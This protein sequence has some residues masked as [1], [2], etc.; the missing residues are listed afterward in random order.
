MRSQGRAPSEEGEIPIE[1]SS[2][3]APTT[4]SLPIGD[5]IEQGFPNPEKASPQ[6]PFTATATTPIAPSAAQSP[7]P[8]LVADKSF[9]SPDQ[10][11][12]A[13]LGSGL[14]TGL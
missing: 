4:T 8:G 3:T 2:T 11:K 1:K 14:T 9:E 5:T 13:Q 10:S 7:D 6:P 12:F